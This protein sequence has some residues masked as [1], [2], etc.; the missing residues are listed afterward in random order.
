MANQYVVTEVNEEWAAESFV[1]GAFDTEE[2]AMALV[3]D[4]LEARDSVI[5]VIHWPEGMSYH[6]RRTYDT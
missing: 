1:R 6:S 4:I 5:Q 2:K 3:N